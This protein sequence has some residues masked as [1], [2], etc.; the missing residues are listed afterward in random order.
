MAIL[1]VF[2][3][4]G[5]LAISSVF[6]F[7]VQDVKIMLIA[8]N[9][10]ITSETQR[11]TYLSGVK[12]VAGGE[13]IIFSLD[14]KAI[15]RE[16]QG[17]YRVRV[18]NI[19]AKF[20]NRIDVI[21][22]ER[23]PVFYFTDD[24]GT[25]EV[26]DDI[27]AILDY[28]LQIISTDT[29]LIDHLVGTTSVHLINISGQLGTP[30]PTF[31]TFQMGDNL[32]SFITNEYI[33]KAGLIELVARFFLGRPEYK[34]REEDICTLFESIQ[35]KMTT[36]PTLEIVLKD[37]NRWAMANIKI[38]IRGYNNKRT[39]GTKLARAWAVIPHTNYVGGYVVVGDDN[40]AEWIR[41]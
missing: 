31:S 30:K 23:Y 9:P 41:E 24:R 7:R 36:Q 3:F 8:T 2:V 18:T 6:V 21:V 19:E 29:A 22:R 37:P 20:P 35:Y 4:V 16:I 13:N 26:G 27:T 25:P 10:D 17:D 33:E 28:E 38:E 11:N 5:G 39:F 12:S 32:R 40:R 1:L 14:R 34:D 15:T